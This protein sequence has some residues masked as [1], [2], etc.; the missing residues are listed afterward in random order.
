M[1][2]FGTGSLYKS[3]PSVSTITCPANTVRTYDAAGLDA[4]PIIDAR[5]LVS[6][7]V[8][9][10]I[11]TDGLIE[12]D[13]TFYCFPDAGAIA[14]A[15]LGGDARTPDPYNHQW[16][17]IIYNTTE[18]TD[19]SYLSTGEGNTAGIAV[20]GPPISVNARTRRA[21]NDK[22]LVRTRLAGQNLAGTGSGSVFV[23][24]D[25]TNISHHIPVKPNGQTLCLFSISKGVG[26]NAGIVAQASLA[27]ATG[28]E[29]TN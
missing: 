10:E 15:M 2:S 21:T 9:L 27:C 5:S 28:M 11:A 18:T 29:D 4:P 3:V 14:H 8:T 19:Q 13:A 20:T 1:N 22:F 24:E 16:L 26:S 7:I 12:N 6:G 23:A 25:D 17:V